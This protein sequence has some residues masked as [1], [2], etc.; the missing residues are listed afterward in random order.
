MDIQRRESKQ[1]KNKE[2]NNENKVSYLRKIQLILKSN[3]YQP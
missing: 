1:G 3:N 2:E